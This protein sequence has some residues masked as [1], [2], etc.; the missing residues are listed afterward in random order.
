MKPFL[1]ITTLSSSFCQTNNTGLCSEMIQYQVL[2]YKIKVSIGF[3]CLY[4]FSIFSLLEKFAKPKHFHFFLKGLCGL[5]VSDGG[6]KYLSLRYEENFTPLVC[7][8][9]FFF[10]FLTIYNRYNYSRLFHSPVSLTWPKAEESLA[11]LTKQ[12]NLL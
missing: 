4:F 11:A 8:F 5:I 1:S 10:W 12:N 6:K 2:A 3:P 9:W 7:W